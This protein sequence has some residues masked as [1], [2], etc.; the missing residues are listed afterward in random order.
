[1]TDPLT[2]EEA[3]KRVRCSAEWLRLAIA[4]GELVAYQ[5]AKCF[6]IYPDDLDTYIRAYPVK[7]CDST[8]AVKSGGATS[9]SK[10]VEEALKPR[11]K[12]K[13]QPAPMPSPP[14]SGSKPALAYS[15]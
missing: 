1:M 15:R 2:L 8:N 12:A 5:P 6:L 4:K 10:A 9:A 14:A 3:S 7:K 13:P 11:K